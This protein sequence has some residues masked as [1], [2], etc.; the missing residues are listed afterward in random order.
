MVS[1][2]LNLLDA[3]EITDGRTGNFDAYI[4]DGDGRLLDTGQSLFDALPAD[5]TARYLFCRH[6]AHAEEFRLLRFGGV[7]VVAVCVGYASTRI[8]PVVVPHGEAAREL[9]LLDAGERLH[10][11]LTLCGLDGAPLQNDV[12]LSHAR[13]LLNVLHRAFLFDEGGDTHPHVI[14]HV[15]SVR[16][17][18][19]AELFGC[20]MRLT[21][22]GLG[23][24]P[25]PT[26]DLGWCSGVLAALCHAAGRGGAEQTVHL[27]FDR[28]EPDLPLCHALIRL[29]DPDDA[30]PEFAAWS[31]PDVGGVLFT[32]CPLPA[33]PDILHVAFSLSVREISKQGV[34]AAAAYLPDVIARL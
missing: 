12:D 2:F 14:E 23:H 29:G 31:G 17:T 18:A 11:R 26:P 16:A 25:L 6:P 30:L 33:H 32:C 22:G 19:M 28:P 10:P 24:A 13:D 21:A 4:A 20:R 1:D 8:M 34:R 3:D 5:G 15:L 9:M 7:P 27:L